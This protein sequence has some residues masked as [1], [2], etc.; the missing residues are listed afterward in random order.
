MMCH[1]G[2]INTL[3]GN[4]NWMVSRE[5]ALHSE[6]FKDS[7]DDL[8]PLVSDNMSDSGNFDSVLQLLTK[9]GGRTLPEAVMLMVPEAWQDNDSL[10][11]AKTSFFQCV[12]V[13][14]TPATTTTTP[15]TATIITN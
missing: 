4:K 8:K 12:R 15:A 14:A 5:S 2:E 1:N 11:A 7:T 9:G 3:R 13:Y 10:S 6:Y